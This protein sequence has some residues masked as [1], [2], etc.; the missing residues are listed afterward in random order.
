MGGGP[1]WSRLAVG[2]L[3]P[4]S[5]VNPSSRRRSR[6]LLDARSR[7]LCMRPAPSRAPA[8]RRRRRSIEW[9]GAV[10]AHRNASRW[11]FACATRRARASCCASSRRRCPASTS[12]AWWWPS[13]LRRSWTRARRWQPWT[14]RR[15]GP[16]CRGVSSTA[17]TSSSPAACPWSPTPLPGSCGATRRCL[18]RS[19]PWGPGEP[20]TSG[21]PTSQ[22]V[23]GRSRSCA[24]SRSR[25]RL[26]FGRR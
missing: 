23:A 4:C 17:P 20:Q 5:A 18:L 26:S 25:R 3:P 19:R 2:R 24:L 10:A 7:D 22:R 12:A 14:G 9:L 6:W 16:C 11:T 15:H 13:A 1:P 21:R 8:P